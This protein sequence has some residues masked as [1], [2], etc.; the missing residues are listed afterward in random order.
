MDVL[1]KVIGVE[2]D[3][4]PTHILKGALLDPEP[5]DDKAVTRIQMEGSSHHGRR[6]VKVAR[7][8]YCLF[9]I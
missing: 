7:I 1:A 4:V 2:I 5:I 6:V 3:C 8:E 9:H